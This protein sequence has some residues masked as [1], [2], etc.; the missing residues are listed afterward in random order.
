MN[1]ATTMTRK[2]DGLGGDFFHAPT[3]PHAPSAFP[4]PDDI[5][6]RVLPNGI[7]VLA[8]ENWA[9]PSAVVEGYLQVGNLDEPGDLPGLS[10]FATSMLTRGTRT[11]PFAEINE[12]IEGMGASV[13]FSAD[14]H[15]T[16]F[17]TKSLVE[18]LDLVLEILADELR[19]PVFPAE[20]IERM[21][22]LRLTALAERENDTRHMAGR[23]FRELMYGAH[24]LGRDLLGT[25]ESLRAID[26]A[27]LVRFYEQYF[28]PQG[29]VVAVV[30]ALRAEDAVAKIEAVFG[31]W[32]RTRPARPEL[33]AW[34]GLAGVRQRQV[35][36]PEK[37]QSDIVLGWP[38]MRRLDPDFDAARLANTVLGV[39]G[40]MGRLG[41]NVRER[42][43]MAYYAY[44][45]LSVDREPGTWAAIAGVN[46]ANV[47]RA[48][49]AMLDEVKRLQDEPVAADE[50]ADSKSYLTGTLPLQLETN[51][52]VASLLVDLEWQELGLDY[53][54]RYPGIIN[55]LTAEQVQAAAQKYLDP[56]SY[57]LVVA[58]PDGK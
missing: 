55:G 24:P 23:A 35:S 46:P 43:G 42:Q 50:L 40:M 48:C 18:D 29:M 58:G 45:R 6:R 30:G 49:A 27:A 17:S 36:M 5:L 13:G 33:P 12:T 3:P 10:S 28:G 57:V 32:E 52:G 34:G 7:T 9:A 38:A 54:A 26:R 4:G 19:N 8:R 21:R 37:T 16:N 22:G 1:R 41:A 44:S 2:C 53:L 25:R 47:P 15:M 20:H 14:R 51:D 56:E 11:R 39:F 31:D